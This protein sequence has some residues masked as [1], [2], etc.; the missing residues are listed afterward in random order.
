MKFNLLG[1]ITKQ[2]AK[3]IN[4]YVSYSSRNYKFEVNFGK[5]AICE[6]DEAERPHYTIKEGG[7]TREPWFAPIEG[8][9]FAALMG[10]NV[11]NVAR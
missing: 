11:R 1:S 9:T 6:K 4:R 2:Y 3:S 7:D 10:H 5:A 8:Y